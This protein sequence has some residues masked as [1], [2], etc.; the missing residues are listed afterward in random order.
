MAAS[1]LTIAEVLYLR[2]PG[3]ARLRLPP[4]MAP[5]IGEPF[6]HPDGGRMMVVDVTRKSAEESREPGWGRGIGPKDAIHVRAAL[7]AGAP[8][9]FTSDRALQGKDAGGDPPLRI[10]KPRWT[11]QPPL[12]D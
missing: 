8:V 3:Q 10:G 6:R 2:R 11:A 12:F 4:E 9:T 5:R 7:A 1:A